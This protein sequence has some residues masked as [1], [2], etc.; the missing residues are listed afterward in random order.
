M[1]SRTVM[2]GD[3]GAPGDEGDEDADGN[4]GGDGDDNN[5]RDEMNAGVVTR[6][7][8][9]TAKNGRKMRNKHRTV[10]MTIM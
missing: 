8:R 10:R 9:R 2:K 7:W 6:G 3:E 1:L 4:E 5:G